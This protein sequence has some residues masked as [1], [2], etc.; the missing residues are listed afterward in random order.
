MRSEIF[1][2]Y[3]REMV[4]SKRVCHTKLTMAELAEFTTLQP[5][6]LVSLSTNVSGMYCN[7]YILFVC[8]AES[9]RLL[10]ILREQHLTS[11]L[12]EVE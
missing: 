11:L 3:Y 1:I 12:G 8:M 7:I 10:I 5:M 6:V 2:L 4:P 9:A